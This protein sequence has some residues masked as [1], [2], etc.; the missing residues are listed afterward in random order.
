[1]SGTVKPL[2]PP[3]SVSSASLSKAQS[4]KMNPYYDPEKLELELVSY[5]EPNLSYQY[6]TLCFWATKDGRIYS[7]SDSGCSC[8][9]PFEDY[10]GETQDE[11]LQKLERVG[12]VVQAESIFDSWNKNFDGKPRIQKSKKQALAKWVAKKLKT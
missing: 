3:T 6:N 12:S 11:V 1:M 7:A 10:E 8:P 5:D 9:I 4:T 2:P